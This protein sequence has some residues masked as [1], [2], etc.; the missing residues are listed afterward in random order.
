MRRTKASQRSPARTGPGAGC[1]ATADE[2]VQPLGVASGSEPVRPIGVALA[3]VAVWIVGSLI[4]SVLM[5]DAA[6]SSVAQGQVDAWITDRMEAHRIPG[7]A[8]AVV[9][10]G[11]T[12]H[13]R[14]YG[15]A[16]PSGEPVVAE[17][18]FLIGSVSKPFTAHVVRQLVLD[19]TLA[20][21]EP[22]LPYLA[23]LISA[24]PDGFDAVTVR[25]LLTHTAGIGMAVGL[26]GT[27]PIHT[28]DDALD[29]RVRDVL[30]Y[31]LASPPGEQYTYSN[32][33]Y[34]LLAAVVEQVTGQR[35]EEV[36]AE[37][38]F[39]PL[40]MNDTFASEDHAAA[41]R[42]A[43]GHRQWFG[44][45]LPA[46][47]AFDRAGVAYGY[48]GSTIDDLSRFLHAY[49]DGDPALVPASA[50]QLARDPVEPTGW[51]LPLESGQGLGWMVDELAGQRVVSHAGSLGHFTAH[52]IMVPDADGLGIAV[53][54]NASAFIA[55]GH[56]A[57]YDLSLGL[58]QLLLGEE[59]TLAGYNP[60]L[61]YV[62]P[63][64]LW[65]LALA[66][67]A[68]IVRHVARTQPRV[69]HHTRGIPRDRRFWLRRMI[70]PSIGYLGGATAV[71]VNV[72][73]GAAR[74]FYPDAG[75]A[76]T[77][78]TYLALSWGVLRI[79]FI[80]AR[81]RKTAVRELSIHGITSPPAGG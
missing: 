66:L 75:T 48:L 67:L 59:P 26:P 56:E 64:L 9:R 78:I 76:L 57:Q 7:V 18:P 8:V 71:L 43:T 80:L 24:P 63:L 61:V 54:T 6:G 27:V 72:P 40:G 81:E 17:T 13:L 3:V 37:Q 4:G 23:D 49:L 55:A 21:D 10:D 11:R 39:D 14:G 41:A 25:H 16:G 2:T 29:Q 58:A 69:R 36:L 65:A 15:A 30:A 70:L 19:G 5:A 34:A 62:A 46:D 38:I 31:P 45:W 44:A 50:T 35:F 1:E 33:G 42:V 32:A 22:V 52:L 47:L 74:H 20:L 53:V 68:A 77:V 12:V 73:L 79:P 60:L 28:T 51:N